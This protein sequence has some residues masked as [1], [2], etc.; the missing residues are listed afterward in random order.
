VN[1]GTDE[2]IN[3]KVVEKM[4]DMTPKDWL[5]GKDPELGDAYQGNMENNNRFLASY[6][7]HYAV[8]A[9]PNKDTLKRTLQALSYKKHEEL[10]EGAKVGWVPSRLLTWVILSGRY[11]TAMRIGRAR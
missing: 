5:S 3:V 6:I 4:V 8:C 11:K 7:M 9:H 1:Y 2:H 10:G